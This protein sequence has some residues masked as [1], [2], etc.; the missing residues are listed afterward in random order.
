MNWVEVRS[1]DLKIKKWGLITAIIILLCILIE[2]HF[3]YLFSYSSMMSRLLYDTRYA[4]FAVLAIV[5]F[6]WIVVA[7]K[8][9]LRFYT[10]WIKNYSVIALLSFCVLFE[11]SHRI[12]PAQKMIDTLAIGGRYASVLL[13]IPVMFGASL[14]KLL[15]FGL[16][17]SGTEITVLLVGMVVAFLVSLLVIKF[18]MNYIKK[19]DFKVF[20]WYRIILGI[21]VL[22]LLGVM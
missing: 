14:L 22:I 20:G 19:H 12:Y 8:E 5:L 15:G 3:F 1:I 10:N 9:S 2:Y 6:I 11:Y 17:F 7:R 21:I 16:N 4:L 18:L 13:A